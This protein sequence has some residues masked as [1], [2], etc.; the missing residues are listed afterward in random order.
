MVTSEDESLL[1]AG[2]APA[3]IL[4]KNI[5]QFLKDDS[6]SYSTYCIPDAAQTGAKMGEVFLLYY[7]SLIKRLKER[8]GMGDMYLLQ[9]THTWPMYLHPR[10]C[11]L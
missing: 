6:T 9:R 3:P 10:S 1:A 5:T 11:T 7:Y 4:R 2:L 8:K